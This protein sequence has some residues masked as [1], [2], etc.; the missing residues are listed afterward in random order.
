[1][2]NTFTSISNMVDHILPSV[3]YI[4]NYLLNNHWNSDKKIGN[5]SYPIMF[6]ISEKD[7]LV[8]PNHM[9]ILYNLAEKAKY[10]QKVNITEYSILYRMGLIMKAGNVID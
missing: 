10:K 7:E 8:P 9:H 3:K 6:I 5:I 4:K 1:L 2:E